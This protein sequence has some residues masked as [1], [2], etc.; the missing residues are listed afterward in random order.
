VPER[1]TIILDH[2]FDTIAGVYGN[3]QLVGGA[4]DDVIFGEL[5]NDQ[6]HGDATLPVTIAAD[7]TIDR[8][9]LRATATALF[10]TNLWVGAD[11]DGDDYLEGNG[12]DDLIFGGLGQDDIVDGSSAL[13]GLATSAQR[14]DG[15][16]TIY[17]GNGTVADDQSPSDSAANGRSRD[18]DVIMGDN[19]NIFRL[20]GLNGVSGGAFLTFSYA[21]DAKQ[22]IV[23]G[24]DLL[25]Y[26]I[27][28]SPTDIG[29]ADKIYGEAGDDTL[30]GEVGD[31]LM[32]GNGNDDNLYGGQGDDLIYGGA[33]DDSISNSDELKAPPPAE[34]QAGAAEGNGADGTA[35]GTVILDLPGNIQATLTVD[36]ATGQVVYFF[37]KLVYSGFS[38][39]PLTTI[40][41]HQSISQTSN[42]SWHIFASS[43]VPS[44][45]FGNFSSDANE[46][47]GF[48]SNEPAGAPPADGD[49]PQPPAPAD[50]NDQGTPPANDGNQPVA[51]PPADGE[52]SPPAAPVDGQPKDDD[53]PADAKTDAPPPA[54]GDIAPPVGGDTPP[55][56][57]PPA[58]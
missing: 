37:P 57:P 21:A 34:G 24:F 53:K 41:S 22:I 40:N 2:A 54:S 18:A 42:G 5:G 30:H 35:A 13:F 47:V 51:T 58:G 48:E 16:D 12:G 46:P 50:G 10:T 11:S 28:E 19:A 29:A 45:Q 52:Q 7:G 43:V 25:D 20:V 44:G 55:P 14:P 15:S 39:S 36:V 6:L 3:D 38:N 1:D 31:D 9:A 27:P 23:R 4:G 49:Q 56:P 26:T 33:G 32:Y 8:T 17:G